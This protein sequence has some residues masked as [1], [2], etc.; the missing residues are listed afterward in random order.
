MKAKQT[1]SGLA[2]RIWF[3]TSVLVG[4]SLF[5]YLQGNVGMKGLPVLFIVIF[6]SLAVSVPAFL[7]LLFFLF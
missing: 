6:A 3:S 2:A 4:I 7:V 5:L 1:N